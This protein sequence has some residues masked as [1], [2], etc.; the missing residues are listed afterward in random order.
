[1]VFWPNGD[2]CIPKSCPSALARAGTTEDT[3]ELVEPPLASMS[4]SDSPTA[5]D[6]ACYKD[7]IL[8]NMAAVCSSELSSQNVL[9]VCLEP[10]LLVTRPTDVILQRFECRVHGDK[11]TIAHP[12]IVDVFPGISKL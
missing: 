11:F 8:P 4:T 10:F 6:H 9:C 1:M 2:R 5:T 3:D 12:S 7:C